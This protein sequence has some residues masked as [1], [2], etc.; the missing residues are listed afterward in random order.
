MRKF[1]NIML[2]LSIVSFTLWLLFRWYYYQSFSKEKIDAA[3]ASI[4]SEYG[5]KI[6]YEIGD[7]FFSSLK[8]P[9]L[10]NGPPRDSKVKA[11]RHRVLMRYPD[12]LQKAL[13]KYPS[14]VIKHYLKAIY[15]AGE[16][17]HDGERYGGTYDIYKKVVYLVDNGGNNKD[18][19]MYA[20]HHEL[21]SLLLLSHTFY[22]APWL[23]NNPKGFKYLDRIYDS[24]KDEKK[25]RKLITDIDCYEK[26]IVTN[27]GITSFSNDFSEYSAMIFTY[28]NKFKKIMDQYPRVRGKFKVWLE[29][30]QEIDPIFTEEYLLG[31]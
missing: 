15:F 31:K 1:S 28:P 3:F 18:Q 7:D 25:A 5:I 11:I 30:Y 19:A 10:P 27:Y 17:E 2:A 23:K 9:K 6:V 8:N 4:S 14:V 13:S 29:F 26:G 22:T 21:T 20:F 24:W 16:I 12:V